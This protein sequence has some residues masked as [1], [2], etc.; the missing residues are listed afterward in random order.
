LSKIASSNGI[1]SDATNEYV[2]DIRASNL[3]SQTDTISMTL[4]L[5]Y[6]GL[7]AGKPHM[8]QTAFDELSATDIPSGTNIRYT[9][10]I[11]GSV[12]LNDTI[13]TTNI[14][15]DKIIKIGRNIATSTA[16]FTINVQFA[17]NSALPIGFKLNFA[18][19]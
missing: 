3:L 16:V 10:A 17:R 1:L 19:F 12:L 2:F 4:E 9:V 8:I 14:E 18:V 15:N 5:V 6:N 13:S 11:N 7:A